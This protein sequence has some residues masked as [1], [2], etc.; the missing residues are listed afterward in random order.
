LAQD[1]VSA[2]CAA[3]HAAASVIDDLYRIT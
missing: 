2:D 3:E 1:F